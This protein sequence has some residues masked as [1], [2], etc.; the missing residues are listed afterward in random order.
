GW[1]TEGAAEFAVSNEK[2]HQGANAA[3]ITVTAKPAYQKLIRVVDEKP[4]QG[5][6]YHVSV[7]VRTSGVTG[8]PGAYAAI[9]YSDGDKRLEVSHGGMANDA[10][11]REWRQLEVEGAAPA[12]ANRVR[13]VLLLHATGSA[14]F[15]DVEVTC[16]KRSPPPEKP[17]GPCTI[18]VETGK[19]VQPRFGGVG[20]HCSEHEHNITPEHW[21]Q[22]LA[23]RWRELRP[24]FARLGHHY[25]VDQAR[26]ERMAK[27]LL[28][29]KETQTEAYLTTWNP[30]DT[31]EGPERTAYAK[32]I[33]D[34]LE[35]LVRTKGCT[36]LKYYCMTN[37]LSLQQ[38]GSLQ[39]D[40]PK[41]KS[42][43]K[44]LYD[45][46][47]ARKL[48]IQL[49]ATDAS[50]VQLWHT[51]EWAAQ[52]MDDITGVYGGHHYINDYALEDD[53][54]YGWFLGKIQWGAGLARGKN[55]NFVLGEF[56]SKQD[57]R[58][59]AGVKL[60]RCVY[61]ETPQELLAALQV[62]EAA[63]AAINGGAYALGYWTF[64]DYPDEY[65]AHYQNKWG[66]FRWSKA[67]YSTRAVYYSYGLLT[68]FFRGPATVFS[69]LSSDPL[70]RAAAVQH[71]GAKTW[72]VA[73]LNRYKGPAPVSIVLGE[74]AE[75]AVFRKYV[76]DTARA[77]A[78]PFG[79]MQA[80]DSTLSPHGG[81]LT[82]TVPPLS[83][84][85]YTTA[86][87]D[88]PPAP[89]KNV[90]SE[91]VAAG[92]CRIVWSASMEPDFCYYRVYRGAQPDFVPAADNQIASTI[93]TEFLD[94]KA[95]SAA[96]AYKVLAVDQSGNASKP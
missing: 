95:G 70:L 33:V 39:N 54:F 52:N 19:I 83:L 53:R 58:T 56:G 38:W 89:V 62:C 45:E 96:P 85:V 47:A 66:T 7:W 42:Y 18:R 51:I 31:P 84:T 64:S 46:L 43:H 61:Y 29:M 28:L 4:A 10:T 20:F 79:D 24:A 78:H 6:L 27:Y 93:A 90:K 40:L 17:A 23:K 55:K 75:K 16:M 41:F 1:Q 21:E 48:D 12:G 71:A 2:P 82:D 3:R 44:C 87:G 5:N 59:V 60:D 80:F 35:Y 81:A 36:N 67:D 13:V 25:N 50:P 30:K 26:R 37:E 68:R 77:P 49:L 86:Y 15:D 9:E 14:W 73:V 76:Y 11:A 32:Q 34:D 72:S 57:G 74:V 8:S 91:S 69:V 65:N 92:G 22:V 63:L 88:T 94:T